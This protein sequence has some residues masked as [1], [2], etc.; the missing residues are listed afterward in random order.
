MIRTTILLMFFVLIPLIVCNSQD[1]DSESSIVAT[2]N[3]PVD[4]KPEAENKTIKTPDKKGNSVGS[5]AAKCMIAVDLVGIEAAILCAGATSWDPVGCY[6]NVD[7]VGLDAAILCSGA[8]SDMPLKCSKAVGLVGEDLAILCSGATLWD[9][10]GCFYN[11]DAVGMDIALACTE[12]GW[13]WI[14]Y[15][16]KRRQR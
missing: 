8:T 5:F 14:D 12:K 3:K 15:I 10:V 16:K 4:K 11:T 13:K 2:E 9:P 1:Q 6:Y 7:L